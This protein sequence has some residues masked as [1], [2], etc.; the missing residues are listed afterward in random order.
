M[1]IPVEQAIAALSTFSLEVS[2]LSWFVLCYSLSLSLVA[3]IC[4]LSS[5]FGLF[6]FSLNTCN[7]IA[8]VQNH[9]SMN[10]SV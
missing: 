9:P 6:F 7:D 10:D 8:L 1:A 2:L 3:W 5:A 4:L